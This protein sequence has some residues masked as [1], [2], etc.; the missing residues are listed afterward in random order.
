[1]PKEG[2]SR[3][4]RSDILKYEELLRVIEAAAKVGISKVRITGGEPLIRK[5]IVEFIKQ[6]KQIKDLN[7]ISLTTNGI[8]L[9]PMAED[10]YR[11]GIRRINI[12]LDSLDGEKYRRITRGGDLQAVLEGIG[13]VHRLGFSPIKINTV[14]IK[15]FND[16]EILRFAE[17]AMMKPFQIRFIELMPL[18][19]KTAIGDGNFLSNTVVKDII[20]QKYRLELLD[21]AKMITDGPARIYKLL[22]G[23]GEIG[24]ISPLSHRF[25]AMCNRLRLT[26][27]GW[28]MSCLLNPERI[29]L[30]DALR[31]DCSQEELI[32]LIRQAIM[33]KPG[34]HELS[35]DVARM[36]KC[37]QEMSGIGG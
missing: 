25:C 16:D 27:H 18:G 34:K 32:G 15:G 10:I 14:A 7:D 24:F 13:E 37:R 1:M 28:L 29:D 21:N 22:D 8:I 11:A 6:L 30:K 31:R 20:K 9:A 33:V 19:E 12:S 3:Y 2:L 17:L 36:K 5:G 4:G 23:Q 35:A 26:S